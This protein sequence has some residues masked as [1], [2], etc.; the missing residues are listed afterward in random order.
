MKINHSYFS[1]EN[2]PSLVRYFVEQGNVAHHL[3]DRFKWNV[4]PKFH[5]VAP[6]TTHLDIEVSARCQLSCPMCARAAMNA[7]EGFMDWDLYC[8]IIDQAKALGC[9][10]VKLS[11]RGEPML[12]P[13]FFDMLR[14]AKTWGIRDVAFLTN[15]GPLK[16]EHMQ[17]FID[18]G[19]DWVSVSADGLG[20]TYERIRRP[21]QF[22]ET[23][24]KVKALRELREKMGR[25]K[26]LVRIQSIYSAIRDNP[27]EY[28]QMWSRVADKVNFI[29]DQM[30]ADK[31]R[32]FPRDPSF[33]CQ[34]PWLRFFIG[35]NG[36][37]ANCATDYSEEN[38]MG[39]VRYTPM[40]EIWHN[41]K[42]MKLRWLHRHYQ[43]MG[44]VPCRT[45]PHTGKMR[46][47]TVDMG[48]RQIRINAFVGQ[49]FFSKH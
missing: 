27:A 28:W 11:W 18:T 43:Y 3:L 14:Y 30:R 9:Y 40:E 15:L 33:Q 17:E 4:L 8:H 5:L 38:V 29:P 12:H 32:D 41:E 24:Q 26:P 39:N 13:K 44:H 2:W 35:W 7:D 47:E 1:M 48:T 49:E 31:D 16:T 36:N 23:Y 19:V 46:S 10:S 21:L 34:S 6:F 20:E 45:C 25:T 42:F 37:V 22:E